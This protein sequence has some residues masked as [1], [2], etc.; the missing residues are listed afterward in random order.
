MKKP[1]YLLL[2]AVWD[3]LVAAG[4]FVLVTFIALYAFPPVI[5]QAYGPALVGVIFGLSVVVLLALV[6]L[7]ISLM[8]GIGLL[9]ARQ[10]GRGL[11]LVTAALSLFSI[12]IGTAVGLLSILYLTRLRCAGVFQP[13]GFIVPSDS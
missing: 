11:T 8:G 12:P 13:S 2:I 9:K 5:A 3:F 1:E 10:W 6:V 4:A 7:I